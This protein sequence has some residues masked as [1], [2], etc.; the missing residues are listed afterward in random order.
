M[1]LSIDKEKTQLENR[2]EVITLRSYFWDV[3]SAFVG[4]E[5]TTGIWYAAYIAKL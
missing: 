5:Y 3:L 2:V 4:Q 1:D